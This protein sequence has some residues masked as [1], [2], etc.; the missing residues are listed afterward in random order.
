MSSQEQEQ[1][2]DQAN[3]CDAS[4]INLDNLPENDAENDAAL[5]AHSGTLLQRK[6]SNNSTAS[7]ENSRIS[8]TQQ[9]TNNNTATNL[10]SS[11]SGSEFDTGRENNPTPIS[12]IHSNLS[13]PAGSFPLG[14]SATMESCQASEHSSY[15]SQNQY[16]K[17]RNE[18][19]ERGFVNS[20][21]QL[22]Q[23]API[24]CCHSGHVSFFSLV[25]V[26]ICSIIVAIYTLINNGIDLHPL[27]LTTS[28]LG[29]LTSTLAIFFGHIR[30]RAWSFIPFMV[31]LTCYIIT[32]ITLVVFSSI[33]WDYFVAM[34]VV[35]NNDNVDNDIGA[36]IQTVNMQRTVL[37]W[38]FYVETMAEIGLVS[39]IMWA[40][41][42]FRQWVVTLS[43]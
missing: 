30:K 22:N 37:Q 25:I 21:S 15:Y 9:L 11:L 6:I 38:V 10:L 26:S 2:I 17:L 23:P 1:L 18:D 7:S 32:R 40:V 19:D 41:F 39:F 16:S 28:I 29:V 20:R 5:D 31:F 33:N 8:I 34:L 35:N 13:S 3:S 36:N 4:Q 12:L 42:T 43:K 24:C 14:A 27:L